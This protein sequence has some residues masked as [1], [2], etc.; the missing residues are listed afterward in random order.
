MGKG[1]HIR[2][3]PIPEWLKAALDQWTTQPGSQREESFEP[4]LLSDHAWRRRI[5]ALGW[6][7]LVCELG[8]F[9]PQIWDLV[10][11]AAAYPDIQFV[12]PVMGWPLDRTH[13]GNKS[14]RGA[15][16]ALSACPN[17][18]VTIF[19]MECIFGIG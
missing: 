6:R 16:A 13:D 10:A 8:V 2:T 1:G 4:C 18:A 12:L 15:L 3:V 19:G 5:A 11:V 9:S 7:G 14:W 17:V